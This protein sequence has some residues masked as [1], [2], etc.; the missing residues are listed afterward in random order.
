MFSLTFVN[1]YLFNR[2]D[3]KV[4]TLKK[5]HSLIP[6][7]DFLSENQRSLIPF[8]K[9]RT[10]KHFTLT[11]KTIQKGLPRTKLSAAEILKLYFDQFVSEN[12]R[13]IS[14]FCT[15]SFA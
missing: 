4:K 10:A 1:F 13:R 2:F 11:K 15:I 12:E 5:K 6:L 14:F 3:K 9:I 7:K 8:A